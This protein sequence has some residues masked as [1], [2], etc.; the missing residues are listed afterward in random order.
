MVRRRKAGIPPAVR[1]APGQRGRR[2][3]AKARSEAD[4]A[5][6]DS[7]DAALAPAFRPAV[8]RGA[9]RSRAAAKARRVHWAQT[10]SSL[11]PLHAAGS[12]VAAAALGLAHH[13]RRPPERR[14]SLDYAGVARNVLPPGQSGTFDFPKTSTDQLALYDGLTPLRDKVTARRPTSASSSRR[15]SGRTERATKTERPRAGLRIVRDKWAVPHV[16]GG[17]WDDVMFGA[18]W[19]TAA[20]SRPA[21]ELCC[22]GPDG[23]PRSTLRGS[24]PLRSPTQR[25]VSSSPECRR[26][27]RVLATQVDL[28]RTTGA[29]RSHERIA[30]RRCL[31]GRNQ[32][33]QPQR[34]SARSRRGHANDV[35][36]VAT[37]IGAVFGA[38][39]GDEA[40]GARSSFAAL[41]RA[42]RC[43]SR[44]DGLERP[45]PA[46]RTRTRLPRSP[47]RSPT[48][49]DYAGPR[50]QRDRGDDGSFEP[51]ESGSAAT[52]TRVP[53]EQR[54]PR[55][56]LAVG[57]R[58]PAVRRRPAGRSQLPPRS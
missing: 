16:Y 13:A 49:P 3:V 34:G 38:G 45:A 36:A 47:G 48:A 23:S 18:G 20:V 57:H 6:S 28:L 17:S 56:P 32:R 2:R 39:G 37:I 19:A 26:P 58:P 4:Q 12:L 5:A 7:G 15:A 29:R 42:A 11:E 54:A 9:A 21:D 24:T 52:T 35:I 51:L 40:R 46:R 10:R 44:L 8:P 53:Y 55:L 27:R 22:A 25:R 1:G 41:Q 14:R 33:V 43:R 50:R 31:R 30:R